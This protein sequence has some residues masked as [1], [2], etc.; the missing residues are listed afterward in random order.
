MADESLH[1]PTNQSLD[2]HIITLFQRLETMRKDSSGHRIAGKLSS[3]TTMKGKQNM[4]VE[5]RTLEFWRLILFIL[6]HEQLFIYFIVFSAGFRCVM[7][8]K[9]KLTPFNFNALIISRYSLRSLRLLHF[10]VIFRSEAF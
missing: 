10:A 1:M 3:S 6:L 9:G 5:I 4:Q 7:H 2:Y 8:L